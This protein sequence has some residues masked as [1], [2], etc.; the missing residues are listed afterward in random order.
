M[1]M[2]I[3]TLIQEFL[4]LKGAEVGYGPDHP[5][6]PNGALKDTV[7][8]YFN[9]FPFLKQ[10]Q[11][12]VDFMRFYAGAW[13]DWQPYPELNDLVID[14]FGFTAVSRNISEE[15]RLTYTSDESILEESGFIAFSEVF[16]GINEDSIPAQSFFFDITGDRD[17]GV[18]REVWQNGVK[19]EIT[20]YCESFLQWFEAIIRTQG[21]L[22]PKL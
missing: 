9:R 12:Y 5:T 16:F 19:S 10:D 1:Q 11:G 7:D 14:I 8:A 6:S 13:V 20:W 2:S 15:D 3:H 17:Q 4:K 18:Y 22:P 21:K